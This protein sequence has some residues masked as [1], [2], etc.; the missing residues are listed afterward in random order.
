MLARV[1]T[2]L[3]LPLFCLA[4]SGETP[5]P[6]DPAARNDA[7]QPVPAPVESQQPKKNETLPR[8][9]LPPPARTAPI[10]KAD[11][12]KQPATAVPV[13]DAAIVAPKPAPIVAKERKLSPYNGRLAP[14]TAGAR[15]ETPATDNVYQ[16]ALEKARAVTIHKDVNTDRRAGVEEINGF[17]ITREDSDKKADKQSSVPTIRAGSGTAPP[18]P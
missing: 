13:G 9:A 11:A 14:V 7:F 17:V 4:A 6:V 16:A 8:T 1:F 2:G 3:C 15:K 18:K 5:R 10:T 12:A